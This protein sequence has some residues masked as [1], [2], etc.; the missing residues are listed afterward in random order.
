MKANSSELRGL[1][2]FRLRVSGE[3]T[4]IAVRGA[5][6]AGPESDRPDAAENGHSRLG[7]GRDSALIDSIL[8]TPTLAAQPISEIT[9]PSSTSGRPWPQCRADLGHVLANTSPQPLIGLNWSNLG[10]RWSPEASL[11]Q[12]LG[13]FELA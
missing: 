13:D 12:L 10:R 4:A 11:E 8:V 9:T 6:M 1:R 5:S 2:N 7:L 3:I